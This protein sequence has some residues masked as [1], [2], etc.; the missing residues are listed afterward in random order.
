MRYYI[1]LLGLFLLGCKNQPS[2]QEKESD[3]WNSEVDTCMCIASGTLSNLDIEVP[4]RSIYY[5][6]T[7]FNLSDW[8]N[9]FL[10]T[11][12]IERIYL[13]LFD[14]A[15]KFDYDGEQKSVPIA[16]TK[17]QSEIP[18]NLEVVPV[19]YITQE[20]IRN[21]PEF[22]ELLYKRIKAMATKHGFKNF[23][24]I[25][26]D[27]DWT[28]STRDKFFG[29]CQN[30]CNLLHVD[31][32]SL[33]ATIRLHQLRDSVP[34]ADCGVLMLY[35]TG[36]IYDSE[37]RNS[38][39]SYE[40]VEPYLKSEIK[41]NLPLSLAY[42][43]YSWSIATRNNKFLC[44]LHQTDFSNDSLYQYAWN[45]TFKVKEYHNLENHS[46]Y[47]GDLIR[48]ETPSFDEIKKVKRL[49][50]KQISSSFEGSIIYHLDHNGLSRFTPNEI[51]KIL[52]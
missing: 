43:A 18:D 19:I 44:I 38:I 4:K 34:P 41:Y 20:A 51:D 25:Q 13:R 46:M 6:K 27:C 33:S 29:L 17:F 8:D 21:N 15:Y 7:T 49:V 28:N 32:I 5:W 3:S 47:E 9:E 23:K 12:D 37:T 39:L 1:L 26:L 16:T 2:K 35:N 50:T 40:D 31:S 11:H 45:N 22:H 10:I 48:K 30:M 24:E 52:K 14:V 42:P 36:S